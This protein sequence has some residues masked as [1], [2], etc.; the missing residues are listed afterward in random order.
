MPVKGCKTS[1]MPVKAAKSFEQEEISRYRATPAA[2][3]FVGFYV[4]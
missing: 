4:S 1:S 2:T 3:Q